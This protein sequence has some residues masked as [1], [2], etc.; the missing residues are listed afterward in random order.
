M[1]NVLWNVF[2]VLLVILLLVMAWFT[3]AVTNLKRAVTLFIAFGLLLAVS[4][5]RLKAPDVALAE[6]I[7]GAGLSGAL[8]LSAIRD[9]NSVANYPYHPAMLVWGINLFSLLIFFVMSWSIV[10]TM[11]SF[12]SVRLSEIVSENLSGSGVSN[13][14]TAVLLNF[15]AYDTL[16]ELAVVLAAVLSIL[17][18]NVMRPPVQPA[19]PLLA[20]MLKWL[21]PLLIVVSGYLLWV[22]AHAPG[23]AFHAGA[24]LAT[25]IILIHQG[26]FSQH[27]SINQALLRGLL[28]CGIATFVI[29]GLVM[30]LLNQSMLAYMQGWEGTLI[31]LI[32]F[33]ATLSIATALTLAY[34]G[35]RPA[36][37]ESGSQPAEELLK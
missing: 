28:V 5:A 15:R 12:D 1:I 11:A 22:G 31:L 36:T 29:I 32:E 18:L 24:L 30:M 17:S 26:G 20:G 25:A 27:T 10:S 13:P 21:V 2:D 37:W 7:I 6:A 8:L 16:L 19:E 35:G 4:W 34:L 3:C 33:A 23:G 9:Q 14:V